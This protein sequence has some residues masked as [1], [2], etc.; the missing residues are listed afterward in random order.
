MSLSD[1]TF[2]QVAG[3]KNFWHLV[4][5]LVVPLVIY[6]L[7]M[8][9]T[10][11]LEDDGAFILSSYF[12]GVSH[13]PGYP[14]HSLIGK[15]FTLIPVSTIAARVHAVSALFG[16]LTCVVVW[17]IAFNLLKNRA[18]AYVCAFSYAISKAF[19]SQSIIAEVYTLNAFFFFVLLYLSM[20]IYQLD[21]GD[22]DQKKISRLLYITAFIFGLSLCNH[23]PLMI[24][25]AP[26]FLVL[27]WSSIVKAPVR[28]LYALPFVCAGLLPYVWLVINSLTD[29]EIS[30]M[31]PLDSLSKIYNF[32][33]RSGYSQIDQST[34]ATLI[35][36]GLF[37]IF[38]L[39]EQILQFT[40]VGGS[41]LVIGLVAQF[42]LIKKQYCIALIVGYV[43][44]SFLLIALLGFDYDSLHRSSIKVYFLVA[45]GISAIWFAIGVFYLFQFTRN[46]VSSIKIIYIAITCLLIG[47]IFLVNLR[48]NDRHDYELGEIYAKA[49]L[50]SVPENSILLV[51]DDITVG[52]I[53][54][55]HFI[56]KYRTDIQ[57]LY[58]GS[59]VF[60]DRIFDP[61]LT[62]NDEKNRLYLEFVRN[63]K[64]PVY[65]TFD[66]DL[67]YGHK[68]W[69]YN[70]HQK[71]SDSND[72]VIHISALNDSTLATIYKQNTKNDRWSE[73]LKKKILIT[74]IPFIIERKIRGDAIDM[75][76]IVLNDVMRDLDGLMLTIDYLKR[77][78]LLDSFGGGEALLTAAEELFNQSEEKQP[79]AR[80]LNYLA[81]LASEKGDLDQAIQYTKASIKI[82]SNT[83]NSALSKLDYYYSQ[84][85]LKQNF[86]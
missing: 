52:T 62:D 63:S 7:T 83:K 50:G 42:S 36:K 67:L 26:C 29:P 44:N 43:C 5:V 21:I 46:A 39:K 75:H 24:L 79:K 4:L 77:R 9:L 6:L 31:G 3:Y 53:G 34:S 41:L 81:V 28:L 15:L 85:R 74:S 2:N 14:I 1:T 47:N 69:L 84:Q 32:I 10:V 22:S 17:L 60:K 23:W 16:A 76:D 70:G 27:A 13:P 61:A 18:I 38:F 35:D 82:W 12:N 86:H 55:M 80:Y 40:Y 49:I 56:Q 51:H 8:P 48:A 57:V 59:L 45:Y 20:R 11:A 30:F 66:N 73:S 65:T 25:S 19:W 33:S 58:F 72:V 54:Y 78:K 68:F 37:A 64:R 71:N